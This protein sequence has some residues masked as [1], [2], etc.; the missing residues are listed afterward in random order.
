MRRSSR[1]R[2]AR[3]VLDGVAE[4][5]PAWLDDFLGGVTGSVDGGG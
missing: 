4:A 3:V 2:P 5:V 1:R